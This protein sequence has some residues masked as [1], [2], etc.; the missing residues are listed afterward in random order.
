MRI[1][2]FY[3]PKDGRVECYQEHPDD[4]PASPPPPRIA[5]EGEVAVG[6]V[7]FATLEMTG[8]EAVG[9]KAMTTD[10]ACPILHKRL[11]VTAGKLEMV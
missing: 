2:F 1:T 4:V 3:D 8:F 6:L 5:Y 10:P 9:F 11:R 7:A